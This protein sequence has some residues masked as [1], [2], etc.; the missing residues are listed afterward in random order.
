MR[1][2]KEVKYVAETSRNVLEGATLK[3][4]IKIKAF[5]PATLV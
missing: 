3:K 5:R 1:I 4:S 2:Y